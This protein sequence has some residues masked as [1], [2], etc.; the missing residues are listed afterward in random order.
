MRRSSRRR[1]E[2]VPLLRHAYKGSGSYPSRVGT[3]LFVLL[4]GLGCVG[5][6]LLAAGQTR[7]IGE[8][9]VAVGFLGAAGLFVLWVVLGAIVS[10]FE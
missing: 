7:S 8:V 6:V 5:L 3:L 2:L 1:R 4:I 10:A 9:L